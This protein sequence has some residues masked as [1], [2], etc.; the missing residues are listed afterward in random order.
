MAEFTVKVDKRNNGYKVQ[1]VGRPH[2]NTV[3]VIENGEKWEVWLREEI[4]ENITSVRMTDCDS[5]ADAI[6][7]GIRYLM[8]EEVFS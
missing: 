2:W 8:P 5:D 4:Q 3:E 6:A 7:Q 1:V